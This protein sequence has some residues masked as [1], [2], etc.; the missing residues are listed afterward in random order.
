ME[1][2]NDDQEK[3]EEE[4][5]NED[6]SVVQAGQGSQGVNTDMDINVVVDKRYGRGQSVISTVSRGST[7]SQL[8]EHPTYCPVEPQSVQAALQ[9]L[10]ILD[11]SRSCNSLQQAQADL[12]HVDRTISKASF[13]L[14]KNALPQHIFPRHG[15]STVDVGAHQ[16][17]GLWVKVR[18]SEWVRGGRIEL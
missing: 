11:P 16:M 4:E 10:Y 17:E 15:N 2:G 7:S 13:Q 6:G 14:I 9:I 1:M 8:P 5:D 12:A 18:I 3:E